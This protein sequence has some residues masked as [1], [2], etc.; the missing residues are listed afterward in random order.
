[1]YLTTNSEKKN[2]LINTVR[3]QKFENS[4]QVIAIVSYFLF[5]I[6][7][8]QLQAKQYCSPVQIS[9]QFHVFSALFHLWWRKFYKFN[10]MHF[11]FTSTLL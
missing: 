2:I 9:I 3:E 1:M 4:G 8:W 10:F 6:S 5:T 7:V 11:G